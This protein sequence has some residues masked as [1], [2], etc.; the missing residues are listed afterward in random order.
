[1]AEYSWPPDSDRRGERAADRWEETVAALPDGVAV[2]GQV[3]GRQ[4]FGV[5]VEIDGV[6]DVMGLAEVTTMPPGAVLPAVGTIVQGAVIDHTAHNH[7]VRLLLLG[8]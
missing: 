8:L 1:M 7:Q 2:T 5:F 6:S 3:I 4:P